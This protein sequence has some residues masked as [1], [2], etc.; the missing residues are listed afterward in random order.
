VRVRY[1]LLSIFLLTAQV[2]F[3][4]PELSPLAPEEVDVSTQPAL[5]IDNWNPK[6][7]PR[8]AP[9]APEPSVSA[10]APPPVATAPVPPIPMA[11]PVSPAPSAPPPAPSDTHLI[12]SSGTGLS[13]ADR[14]AM[15]AMTGTLS[16]IDLDGQTIRLSVD[17]GINPQLAMDAKTVVE[18]G[19][20]LLKITDLQ[21]GDTVI[22]RYLGQDLTARDI[23]R[24]SKKNP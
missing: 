10:P 12:D 20:R 22:V 9:P 14:A 5:T 6:P 2:A 13:A 1:R 8:I 4:A 7:T 21:T 23:E 3:G 24:I 15:N 19:G 17:G 16:S 11:P 18:S